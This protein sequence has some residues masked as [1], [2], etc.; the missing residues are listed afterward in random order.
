MSFG[1]TPQG[2]VP[3]RLADIITEAE[4]NLS[5]IVDPDSGE[6]LDADFSSND[7]AMQ[8]VKVPLDGLGD[9]WS[10]LQLVA[11]QYDPDNAAGI[12]LSKLVQLNGINRR[13]GESDEDLRTR[14]EGSTLAPSAAPA[15]AIWSNLLDIEGVEFA[16]VYS[17][18]TLDTDS[19][20][21]PGK[22]IAAVV[23]G[24]DNIEIAKVL[25]ARTSDAAAWFGNTSV[26]FEDRQGEPYNVLFS[27]PTE[28]DIYI[29]I[30][31][32]I[33]NASQW[34]G[35]EGGSIDLIKTAIINYAKKGARAFGINDGFQQVGFPPG[36]II[37]TSRLYTA[38]NSV[39]G[40]RIK[41]LFIDDA[42]NPTTRHEIETD[43]DQLAVFKP[44]NISVI[45][46]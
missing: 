14:R 7:P 12:L 19:N 5:G 40:H 16:R 41:D 4:D 45:I 30:E 23:V 31:L 38:I 29:R 22:S 11:D 20:G 1:L 21:I 3:K 9:A 27:R 36:A 10:A 35:G 13:L 17:N 44:A 8:I 15:E 28:L 43:F 26:R 2:F 46:E 32:E 42:I 6:M 24:G 34:A 33:T 37:E 39:P 18:R 25:L